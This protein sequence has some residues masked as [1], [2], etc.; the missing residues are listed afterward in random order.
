MASGEERAPV[1][2]RCS[3]L[4]FRGASVLLC[5]RPN[6]PP[7]VPLTVPTVGAWVL[8]GGTPRPGENAAR[9]AVREVAEETGLSVAVNRVAFVMETTSWEG[10]HHLVEIV[11]LATEEGDKPPPSQM[12]E[13]LSPSFVPLADLEELEMWPPIG[14]YIRG[15][16]RQRSAEMDWELSTAA[17]LGNLWRGEPTMPARS[18]HSRP[19]ETLTRR[20]NTP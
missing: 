18:A 11:F 4:L 14:G 12:E 9:A 1:D 8:P 6:P 5:R 7:A 20:E 3:V 2:V 19:A 17:W 16:P 10:G 13:Q 15:F